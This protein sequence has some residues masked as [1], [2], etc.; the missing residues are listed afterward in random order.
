MAF[1]ITWE[2]LDL[3]DFTVEYKESHSQWGGDA[4][5]QVSQQCKA[6]PQGN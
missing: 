3:V 6:K 1:I 5:K 2:F 4:V